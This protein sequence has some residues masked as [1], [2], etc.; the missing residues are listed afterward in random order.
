MATDLSGCVPGWTSLC[1]DYV[2]RV[3]S[4]R[5]RQ[6]DLQSSGSSLHS[7]VHNHAVLIPFV[8][9]GLPGLAPGHS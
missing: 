2:C 3:D 8:N 6:H 7:V 5:P 4:A 1:L 9:W